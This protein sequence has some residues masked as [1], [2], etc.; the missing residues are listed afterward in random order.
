MV[1]RE[2]RFRGIHCGRCILAALV[3]AGVACMGAGCRTVTPFQA[4]SSTIPLDA[5][6]ERLTYV[7]YASGKA[8]RRSLLYFLPLSA[9]ASI[10]EAKRA[11]LRDAGQRHQRQSIALI[12]VSIDVEALD[13]IVFQRVCTWV[14]GKALGPR[15][16]VQSAKPAGAVRPPH[17]EVKLEQ[18][19]PVDLLAAKQALVLQ[20]LELDGMNGGVSVTIHVS[21]SG[22]PQSLAFAETLAQTTKVCIRDVLKRIAYRE[23]ERDY[24]VAYTFGVPPQ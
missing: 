11:A 7:G 12:D 4:L 13:Y 23:A 15:P 18:S 8:C 14:R 6:L 22:V 10:A 19:E 3:L 21:K 5:E 16:P 2:G 24:E 1:G 20:C 9:D 17:D